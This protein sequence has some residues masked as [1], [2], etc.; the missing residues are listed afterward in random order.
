[1]RPNTLLIGDTEFE[2]DPFY[3]AG[4]L[5]A[6]HGVPWTAN[7]HRAGSARHD[8]WSRGHENESEAAHCIAG[9]DVID[10]KPRGIQFQEGRDG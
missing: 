1:M 10:A 5:A 2:I 9:V 8:Q 3:S 4:A 7:P 6:R